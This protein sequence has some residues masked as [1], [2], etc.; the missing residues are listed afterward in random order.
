MTVKN[1]MSVENARSNYRLMT[2]KD[3]K[4]TTS[5]PFIIPAPGIYQIITDLGFSL[6]IDMDQNPFSCLDHDTIH[7][8]DGNICVDK[9]IV[10]Q[11][12]RSDDNRFDIR[13]SMGV[14]TISFSV[15]DHE[16]KIYIYCPHLSFTTENQGHQL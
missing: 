14:T 11:G 1:N 10:S 8:I 5:Y 9:Y 16:G 15:I 3:G 6:T 13:G 12:S 2:F 7:L 4:K